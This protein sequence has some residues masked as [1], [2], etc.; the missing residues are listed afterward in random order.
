M[1]SKMTRKIWACAS[2]VLLAVMAPAGVAHADQDAD[3]A[4]LL[5]THGIHLGTPAKTGLMAKVVCKDLESGL[6]QA[7]EVKQMT[8]HQVSQAQAEFFVGAA[9]EKYCP[10]KAAAPAAG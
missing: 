10:D 9:T 7:D 1:I 8:D 2:G 6:S 3:F 4:N 5:A